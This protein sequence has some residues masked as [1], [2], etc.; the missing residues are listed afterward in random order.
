MPERSGLRFSNAAK[1]AG[2]MRPAAVSSATSA[3]L[4]LLHTLVGRR[5]VQRWRTASS[6]TRS[7]RESIQPKHSASGTASSQVSP[8]GVT[9]F[10]FR[11]IHSSL[12]SAWFFSSHARNSAASPKKIAGRSTLPP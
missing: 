12:A 2:R 11:P 6:S 4:T 8:R 7:T 9:C 5:G 10:L 1:P 3:M